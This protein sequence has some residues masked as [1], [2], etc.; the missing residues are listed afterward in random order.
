MLL[1]EHDII[2]SAGKS[3]LKIMPDIIGKNITQIFDVL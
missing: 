3:L 2:F 1:N